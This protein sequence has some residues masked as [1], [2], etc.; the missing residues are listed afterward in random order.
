MDTMLAAMTAAVTQIVTEST[1]PVTLSSA[2]ADTSSLSSTAKPSLS[3]KLDR[4]A[5]L[6]TIAACTPKAVCHELGHHHEDT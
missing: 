4:T 5:A 1:V 3:D 2:A 6:T